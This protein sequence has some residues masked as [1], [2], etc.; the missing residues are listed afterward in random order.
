MTE[1]LGEKTQIFH[2]QIS[3]SSAATGLT[4][5]YSMHDCTKISFICG[6]GSMAAAATAITPTFTVRQS[7]DSLLSTSAAVSGA[8]AICGPTTANAITNSRSLTIT[9]TTSATDTETLTINGKTVSAGTTGGSTV[10]TN[11]AFGSSVG[12]TASGGLDGR[13]NSLSSVINASTLSYFMTAATISTAA[14]RL[15]PKDTAST[16]VSVQSTGT[17]Y[18][19]TSEKSHSQIDVLAEDLNSTSQY[20]GL[21]ISTVATSVTCGITVIK[22]GLRNRPG[23][24]SAQAYKKST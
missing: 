16:G 1:R 10:S 3:I 9:I 24:Q 2:E 19:V 4:N 11:I 20:V 14:I 18:T 23:Y 17:A 7:A 6:V 13:V 21:H 22:E 8:T 5:G 12:A 15:T